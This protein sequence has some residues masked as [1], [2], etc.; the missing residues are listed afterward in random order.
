MKKM[1]AEKMGYEVI[2]EF[3]IDIASIV[4]VE[5]EWG[6]DLR[7]IDEFGIDIASRVHVKRVW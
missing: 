1:N 7:V 6:E 5:D 2:D 4:Y 3:G